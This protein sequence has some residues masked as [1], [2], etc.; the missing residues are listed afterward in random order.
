M[1]SEL[2][3]EREE[4]LRQAAL[5]RVY[6][7]SDPARVDDPEYVR[8]LRDAVAAAISY[9]IEGLE[10]PPERAEPVPP[11]LLSQARFAARC[12]VS[13]ETVLRRYVA[14]Y[15][16][17]GDFVLRVMGEKPSA[18]GSS[19]LQ[20]AWRSEAALL[21]RLIV[22]V[23][24][25]YRSELSQ[26]WRSTDYQRSEQVR[27]LLAGELVDTNGFDYELEAWHLGVVA[28]GPDAKKV[29]RGLAAALDRLLLCVCAGEAEWAWL[30]GREP[31][32]PREVLHLGAAIPP[33]G[34]ALALGEAGYGIEGWRLSHRQARASIPIALRG[35]AKAVA[36]ADVAL[37]STAVR[38]EVLAQSLRETYLA[39]LETATGGGKLLR[40]TLKAY[41]TAGHNISSTAAA[42]GVSRPTVKARLEMIEERIGRPVQESTAGIETALQLEEL[43]RPLAGEIRHEI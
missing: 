7:V 4:E 37:L 25:A 28:T 20:Q 36:Y 15:A 11:E 2:L 32:Q 5:A 26:R 43:S 12:G 21:D 33:P 34:G 3:R 6:G 29:L 18:I 40:E 30:G 8:G 31:L 27:R 13:I 24:D 9:A 42:L 17:L 22:A 39:P 19:E 14:G 1:L 35:G 16:L 38:D 10:K 23:A 41:L